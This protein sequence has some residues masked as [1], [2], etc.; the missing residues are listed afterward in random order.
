MTPD[1]ANPQAYL[2]FD[3]PAGENFLDGEAAA[4]FARYRYASSD[5]SRARRQQQLI[6][7]IREQALQVNAIPKIPELWRTLA[8]TFK[9][10]LGLVEVVRLANLGTKLEGS[11]VHGLVFSSLAI[12]QVMVGDAQVLK[13]TDRAQFDKELA[14]LSQANPSRHKVEKARLTCAPRRGCRRGC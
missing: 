2:S 10:D 6:W 1:P 12:Q 9:T 14:G 5:F 3:L 4:K 13:V 7:A 11:Q 8:S